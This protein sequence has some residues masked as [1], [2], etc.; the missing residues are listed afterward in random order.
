MYKRQELARAAAL[1]LV[2]V[3]DGRRLRDRLAVR[4]LRR[5]DRALDLELAH[6][7]VADDLEVELAHA[8]DDGLR[9]FLVRRDL[10]SGVLFR[11]RLE[12]L[13]HHP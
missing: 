13:A 1:L 12:R 7:A 8:G 11:Q 6:H 9:R 10:E 2:R 3:L 5:A 4:D